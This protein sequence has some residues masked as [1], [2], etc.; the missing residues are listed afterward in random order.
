VASLNSSTQEAKA[1]SLVEL[2]EVEDIQ[3]KVHIPDKV[4]SVEDIPVDVVEGLIPLIRNLAVQR[5]CL[6]ME[7][8]V[9]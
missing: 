2:D 5:D 1:Q 8:E 4:H 6:N 7:L 9:D 3:M